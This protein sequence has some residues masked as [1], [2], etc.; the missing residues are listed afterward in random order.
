MVMKR[1]DPSR[2]RTRSGSV[3]VGG[4]AVAAAAAAAA[5]S[6]KAPLPN[7]WNW[8]TR[9]KVSEVRDQTPAC[10]SCW[11]FAALGEGVLGASQVHRDLE[12]RRDSSRAPHIAVEGSACA[13]KGLCMRHHESQTDAHT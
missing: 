7:E 13:M 3:S 11:A 9:G 1:S 2:A 8:V 12:M 10:G 5:G 6:S 4:A